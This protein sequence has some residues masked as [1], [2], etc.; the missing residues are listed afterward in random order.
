M[1]VCIHICLHVNVYIRVRKI[2]LAALGKEKDMQSPVCIKQLGK[3]AKGV[4]QV[5]GGRQTLDHR[6]MRRIIFVAWH[7]AFSLLP[8][9]ALDLPMTASILYGLPC[10]ILYS[11]SPYTDVTFTHMSV[12]TMQAYTLVFKKIN[13]FLDGKKIQGRVGQ[14]GPA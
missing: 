11:L 9:Y 8:N 7:M 2:L 10:A 3:I 1:H 4:E 12:C 13:F 6:L 14:E 5:P